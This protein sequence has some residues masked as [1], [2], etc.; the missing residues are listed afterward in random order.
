MGRDT[1]QALAAFTTRY[2]QAFRASHGSLP[3]SEVLH[4]MPSPCIVASEGERVLWQPVPFQRGVRLSGVEEALGILVHPDI[5]AFYTSQFAGDMPA[6]FAGMS[7][8]L[9]QPWNND[10]VIR[11]QKSDRPSPDPEAM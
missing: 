10:D 8:T 6:R 1:E 2:C 11:V 4:D 9:L 3:A 7:L 5:H